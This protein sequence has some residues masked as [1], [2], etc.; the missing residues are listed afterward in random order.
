M[1]ILVTGGTGFLGRR[2]VSELGPRHSL[3]L[4]G[5][6]GMAKSVGL[7]SPGR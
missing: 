1:K 2:I 4:L 6:H 7:D 5:H 3:R